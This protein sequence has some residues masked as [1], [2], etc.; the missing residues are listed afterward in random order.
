MHS[1][2]VSREAF[3]IAMRRYWALINELPASLHAEFPIFDDF[4]S[5]VS[6]S[7]HSSPNYDVELS[8]TGIKRFEMLLGPHAKTLL[9]AWAAQRLK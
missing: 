6:C 3:N 5:P 4:I 8:I 9:A 2:T 1:R 7:Y